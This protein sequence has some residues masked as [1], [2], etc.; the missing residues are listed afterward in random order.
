MG[1]RGLRR[2]G[3]RSTL[4]S[5]GG[6]GG[7][8]TGKRGAV[9]RLLKAQSFLLAAQGISSCAELLGDWVGFNDRAGEGCYEVGYAH[10][11]I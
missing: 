1:E 7:T 10:A 11:A 3:E 5:N 8:T 2:A 4:D 6:G 9:L